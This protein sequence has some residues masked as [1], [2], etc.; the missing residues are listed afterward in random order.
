MGHSTSDSGVW[1]MS[2]LC[3][4][5]G[6]GPEGVITSP[7]YPGIYPNNIDKIEQ[8]I[9]ETGK[10]LRLEFTAF[11]VSVTFA[12]STGSITTCPVDFVR[13]TDGDGTTL[14]NNSCG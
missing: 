2:S 5:E 7:N 6:C 9:V 12:N 3:P 1:Q 11:S 10:I 13:I 8:I 14:M 4:V